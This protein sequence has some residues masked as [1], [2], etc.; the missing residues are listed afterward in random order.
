MGQALFV[1]TGSISG[2]L[3]DLGRYPGVHRTTR[4]EARVVGEVYE[5]IGSKIDE[6]LA[7]LD[8]YEGSE[9]QRIRVVVRLDDGRRHRAWAY[10]LAAKPARDAREIRSGIYKGSSTRAGPDQRGP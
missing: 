7:A 3:Y 4:Q 6:R 10:V 5:L 9:F 2:T 8:R 1:G